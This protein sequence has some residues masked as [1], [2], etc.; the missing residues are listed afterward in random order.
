MSRQKQ[1]KSVD[2]H[3]CTVHAADAVHMLQG[4]LLQVSVQAEPDDPAAAN[5][6]QLGQLGGVRRRRPSPIALRDVMN[7][8]HTLI[9]GRAGAG[10]GLQTNHKK[11]IK[12]QMS[13]CLTFPR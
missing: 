6:L 4:V 10:A 11:K 9:G 1:N 2:F 7:S 13:D 5:A 8:R 3:T 12:N